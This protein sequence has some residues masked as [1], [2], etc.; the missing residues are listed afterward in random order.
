MPLNPSKMASNVVH[1]RPTGKSLANKLARV[2]WAMLST[3]EGFREELY[4][5]A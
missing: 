1:R 2:C 5:K 3:G 4:A